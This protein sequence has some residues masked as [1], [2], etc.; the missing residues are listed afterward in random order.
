VLAPDLTAHAQ[1][2]HA[3]Q[4][5]VEDDELGT[6]ALDCA[7]RFGSAEH[8]RNR[9]ALLLEMGADDIGERDLV[10]DDE[11]QRHVSAGSG[12]AQADRERAAEP[13]LRA[14]G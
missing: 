12:R 7:K 8:L 2:V 11:Y 4:Q 1:P 10:L 3:G 9:M 5:P 14:G 6:V 13:G